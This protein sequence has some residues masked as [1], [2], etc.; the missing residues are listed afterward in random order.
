[1]TVPPWAS[2]EA[3][4]PRAQAAEQEAH[5]ERL[6]APGLSSSSQL[7]AVE[8]LAPLRGLSPPFSGFPGGC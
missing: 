4:D 1:M 2:L 7:C 6:T 5:R 3:P 8:P